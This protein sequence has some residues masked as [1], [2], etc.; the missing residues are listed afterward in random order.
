MSFKVQQRLEA[1]NRPKVR[2]DGI[3]RECPRIAGISAFG[4]GGSNAHVIIEEYVG[5]KREEGRVKVD[6]SL[7]AIIVLSAK[8]EGQLKV[9]AEKLLEAIGRGVY[10]EDELMDLAYTLQVGREALEERLATTVTGWESL[11]ERLKQYC[12]DP[13][14]N[15][16]WSRGS[17]KDKDSTSFFKSD[18]DAQNLIATW[19]AKG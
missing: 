9:Q 6:E 11:V 4:A 18:D 3:E 7:P 16:E 17:W 5:E 19:L 15:G 8:T 12:A 10:G 13:S 14:H 2:I 1:W